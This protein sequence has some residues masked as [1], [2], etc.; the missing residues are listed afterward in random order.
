MIRKWEQFISAILFSSANCNLI[1]IPSGGELF[2][3]ARDLVWV[4]S[5]L[6]PTPPQTN[7]DNPEPQFVT[8]STR[9][10]FSRMCHANEGCLV[11]KGESAIWAPCHHERRSRIAGSPQRLVGQDLRSNLAET[12]TCRGTEF[13]RFLQLVPGD[14][15]P[16]T[17]GEPCVLHS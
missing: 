6:M 8:V 12:C 1:C 7:K 11:I 2:R 15:E 4:V 5:G 10:Y 13:S 9:I 3:P 17:T 16:Q 14:E